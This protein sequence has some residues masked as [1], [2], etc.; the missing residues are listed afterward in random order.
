MLVQLVSSNY[1]DTLL[2]FLARKEDLIDVE[3]D[4]VVLELVR[5]PHS[6]P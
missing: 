3:L 2:S 5:D 6:I 1:V 4:H